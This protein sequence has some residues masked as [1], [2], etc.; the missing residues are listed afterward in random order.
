MGILGSIVI[1]R[2][3]PIKQTYKTITYSF[4]DGITFMRT[5]ILMALILLVLNVIIALVIGLRKRDV[6]IVFATSLM[7][8]TTVF[9]AYLLAG[10]LIGL[11]DNTA[12]LIFILPIA[13]VIEGFIYNKMLTNKKYTGMGVAFLCDFVW[14]LVLLALV[15]LLHII[16]IPLTIMSLIL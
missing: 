12:S 15:M 8:K 11:T 13:A 16:T 9:T 6:I 7:V 4:S 10:K 5:P 3:E 14:I 2:S 1:N